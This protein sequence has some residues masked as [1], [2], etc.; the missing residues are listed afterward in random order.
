[1]GRFVVALTV[2]RGGGVWGLSD[3]RER[4]RGRGWFGGMI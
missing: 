2:G 3:A 1:M 4:G